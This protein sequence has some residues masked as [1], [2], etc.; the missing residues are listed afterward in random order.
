MSKYL[1]IVESPTKAR[2]LSSFLGKDYEISSSKG[3]IVD[4]PSSKL[5]VDV[6]GD[7]QPL[8]TVLS[9]KKKIISELKKKAKDKE[10]IYLATDPDREGEAIS[11]HIKEKLKKKDKKFYR[12]IFHE[13]TKDA[14]GEA[15]AD[16]GQLDLKKVKA[17]MARRVLDRVVGY[18]LSPL[19]WKKIV[20]GLSAGRVQS[21]A[22]RFIVEKEKEI[23]KFI[24]EITYSLDADLSY[25]EV[26]FSA[27][28]K[29]Y[30]GK[31][32][33]FKD[34][35]E[36]DECRQQLADQDFFITGILKKKNKRKPQ[37]P[38][39]TSSLQQEAFNKLRFSAQKTM[40]IA[41]QLY[42]GITLNGEN[43]GLITYMRTDSFAVSQKAKDVAVDFIEIE[44][45]KECLSKKVYKRKKK[46]G[47]QLAHEAIRPT[48]IRR[49]PDDV[50]Q[51]LTKDQFR[52]YQLI[53][54]RFTASFMAEA[55]FENTKIEIKAGQ[56]L[57][58]AEDKKLV[59]PGFLKLY[60]QDQGLYLPDFVKDDKVNLKA[61]EV[62]KHSTKPPARYNDASLIKILEEKGIGRPST[63]APTIFTLLR[64]NYVRREKSYLCSTDLGVKVAEFLIKHF[65][66][67]MDYGFTAD[68]ETKLDKVEEGEV[69][70]SQILKDFYP[71][72][73]KQVE[74]VSKTIKKE[75][76]YSDKKCPRCGGRLVIKWSRKGKF[77]SCE[78]FPNCRYA[79]SI[80][81]GIKCPDCGKGEILQRR[82]RRGQTFYGCTN[83]PECRYTIRN[84]DQL[85]KESKQKEDTR[86]KIQ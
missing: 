16:P 21:V 51:Y 62:R 15:L 30:Q 78:N 74:K 56:G 27:K 63:Y 25:K 20:R 72:F 71:D 36:A 46:K 40:V 24:P 38:H 52:L 76:V 14:I 83:F 49:K 28:L 59:F 32:G 42:E 31:K 82:N 6:K 37:P 58:L 53:W 8:Y 17:Q 39:I 7:F 12:I 70:W 33:V 29:K 26:D 2:T 80:T 11:W 84:L 69:V 57:F 79:E 4:L 77:L 41:Q 13:I 64:R 9:G 48:D 23:E 81:T 85:E 65:K 66:K 55:V 61:L 34:K 18:R 67:I 54:R 10:A 35:Q 19:L 86:N 60:P 5:A 50:G 68:M 47:A 22:L 1:I 44:F 73:Q 43:I 45:G 75:V 3:H